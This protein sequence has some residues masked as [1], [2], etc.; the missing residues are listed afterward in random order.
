MDKIQLVLRSYQ[1]E[2]GLTNTELEAIKSGDI[3]KIVPLFLPQGADEYQEIVTVALKTI[4]RCID[5]H[6]YPFSGTLTN[7][8]ELDK[9]V[10]Q[11][12]V[13]NEDWKVCF[14][15]GKGGAGGCVQI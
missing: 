11:S 15:D 14:A 13:G 8:V 6:A 3:D 5:R 2:N 4:V 9:P 7:A 1:V 12:L 10:S